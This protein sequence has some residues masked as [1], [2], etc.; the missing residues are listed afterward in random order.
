M[1]K[2][3]V[4]AVLISS[5]LTSFAYA[6][7][8]KA[9]AGP[10]P[11]NVV[12][13]K[14]VDG[15]LS[16][17]TSFVGTVRFSDISN[18]AAESSGKIVRVNFE[19]GDTVSKGSVLAVIDSELLKKSIAEAEAS[20]QQIEANLQLA[21]NDFKRTEKLYRSNATS[22]QDF[23]NKK[24]A[25]IALEKQKSAQHAAI[26]NLKAQ[27]A[28]KLIYSP[29]DGV[30]VSK[31]ISL[32]EWVSSGTPA[33]QVAKSGEMDI[34]VNVPERLLGYMKKGVT[35]NVN[36]SA[37]AKTALFHSLV[38]SGDVT[39]RTFPV[40]FR[41]KDSAGLLEGMEAK[42]DLPS[43]NP[44]AVIFIN[45]DAIV[46]A[47]G[48][49]IVYTVMDNQAKPIPVRIIG[50]KGNQ[51]GVTSE[52]LKAGMPVVIKGNERLRPDQ[53]VNVIGG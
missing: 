36:T 11:S 37:G 10:P 42:A 3:L 35:V 52:H 18:V 19:T 13:G 47:M 25:A 22:E 8:K 34:I 12:T 2:L 48:N 44:T 29:Y 6:E 51:A 16:P 43:A 17:T 32:G 46:K 21:E 23:D 40:K 33:G 20:L 50:Y 38:P 39:N 24:Y 27:L 7:E 15:T 31:E 30:I 1:K 41:T 28:K 5:I 26:A 9:P 4:I 53:P 14:S 49:V 45:R